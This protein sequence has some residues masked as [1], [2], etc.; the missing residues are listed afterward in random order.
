[1]RVL[2]ARKDVNQRV[3]DEH[4]GALRLGRGLALAFDLN[5]SHCIK[6]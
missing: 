5:P 3:E 2:T 4:A 1:V 6:V